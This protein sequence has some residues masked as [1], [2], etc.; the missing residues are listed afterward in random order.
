MKCMLRKKN[1]QRKTQSNYID[2]FVVFFVFRVTHP[3]VAL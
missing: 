1:V 3:V 2:L